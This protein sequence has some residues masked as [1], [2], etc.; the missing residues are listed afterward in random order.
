[1]TSQ[2]ET[3]KNANITNTQLENGKFSLS[4][5]PKRMGVLFCNPRTVGE[6]Q[7]KAN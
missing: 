4:S 7:A 5:L 1:M 2:L 6:S 3:R